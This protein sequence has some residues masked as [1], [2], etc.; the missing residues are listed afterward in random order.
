MF[1]YICQDFYYSEWLAQMAVT[2]HATLEVSFLLLLLPVS[3]ILVI[4]MGVA[5]SSLWK[6]LDIL[7][8]LN[9]LREEE[10]VHGLASHRPSQRG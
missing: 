2:M 1:P 10:L 9:G 7:F 8:L 6:I 4:A 3:I 5:T